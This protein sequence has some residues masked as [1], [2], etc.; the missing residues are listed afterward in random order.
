MNN[1]WLDVKKEETSNEFA[2]I[3]LRILGEDMIKITKDGFY[4]KG[5][6]VKDDLEIYEEFKNFLK[7]S[8]IIN[9]QPS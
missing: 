3:S 2:T 8:Q 7:M 5:R 1:Y 9:E 4:V 6:L